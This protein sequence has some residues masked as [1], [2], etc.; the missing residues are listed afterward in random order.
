MSAILRKYGVATTITFPLYSA[1]TNDFKTDAAHAS[2]DS[3]ISKD[4]GAEANTTNGFVDEGRSYSLALTA[5]EMEAARI[6]ITLIDQGTKAYDDQCIVIETYGHASAQHPFDLGTASTAQTGDAYARL[7]APVGASVSD[8]VAAVK[9]QTAAIETDTQD[10]QGRLP[11]ALVSGRMDS[12]VGSM[13]ANT[14]TASALATDAVTEIQTGLS[15]LSTS[16][17]F[18]EASNAI[19]AYAP[20]KVSDV[21]TLS[22]IQW[23]VWTLP[24]ADV[25]AETGTLGQLI[26]N[27]PDAATT[28]YEVWQADP[29]GWSAAAD[30]FGKLIIDAETDAG[31]IKVVTDKLNDTLEL[32]TSV[33]RFTSNALEQAPTGGGGG[34]SLTAAD[35]WTYGTRELTAG[36]NIVLS[37]GTG[38]TGFNDLSAAQVN[39]E[40]D[41][42][43][44]DVGLTTTI[45]GR[46]DAAV[47][48][49]LA[50]AGYT[51][52]DN[53]S[54]TAIKAKTDNLP[55]DPADQSIIIGATDAILTAVNAVPT[56]SANASAVRTELA[57]ELNRMDAAVSTRSTLDAAGVRSAVGLA[58]ANL[59]T[60]LDAL[61]TAAENATAVLTTAMTESYATD[62]AAP[63]LAQA[64]M[65][66]QQ[67]LTDFAIAGTTITIRKLDGV[68]TAATLTIDDDTSPTSSTRS[69]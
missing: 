63:T 55:S 27:L 20:A 9:T 67:R 16:D 41:T 13:A 57:T 12:S 69:S 47:S 58:S 3:V 4:E 64:V 22:D 29:A 1:G 65:L 60:Q 62:G 37:K 42:A 25:V 18:T 8:D 61:P 5:T 56:A 46:I 38:V 26:T 30:T 11:A 52:P 21:P 53:A 34:G 7:G 51:A 32:D 14:L 45:T 35:V 28:A 31:L 48:T 19:D 49:R 24:Y 17:I 40:V 6:V 10:I 36:T 2:G 68:T 66:T 23:S 33:Y 15:T 59:D 44:A 54:I 43:I 50:S 39:A